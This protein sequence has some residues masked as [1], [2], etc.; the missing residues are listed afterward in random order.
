MHGKP[1]PR[2]LGIALMLVI[3]TTFGSNHIAA[4]LAFDHGVNVTTAVA[5]RSAVTALAVLPLLLA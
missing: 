1:L 4:R 2:W 3:A 5:A